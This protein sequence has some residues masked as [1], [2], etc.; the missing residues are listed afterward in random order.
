M[1][2]AYNKYQQV[3]T[4]AKVVPSNGVTLGLC[5][6]LPTHLPIPLPVIDIAWQVS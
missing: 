3:Y 6:E 5:W 2:W 1:A 4:I